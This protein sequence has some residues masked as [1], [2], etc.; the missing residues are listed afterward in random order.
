MINKI[1]SE[2]NLFVKKI[3]LS[4]I[5]LEKYVSLTL[6]EQS[7]Y[8]K[9][10][11]EKRKIEWLGTRYLLQQFYNKNSVIIYNNNGKPSLNT[12]EQI[13]ISHSYGV[14][15]ILISNKKYIGL[16]IEKKRDKID[17]IKHKFLSKSELNFVE[18]SKSKI[19]TLTTIR[20][21]KDALLKM[22][23]KTNLIMINNFF[24]FGYFLF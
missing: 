21:C 3:E 19:E 9:L 4:V 8:A 5:K 12:G 10:R 20:C 17:R 6:D 14:V 1:T 15:G 7:R 2:Y 24:Y 22:Y 11:N 18:N 16:D 23:G 13:S